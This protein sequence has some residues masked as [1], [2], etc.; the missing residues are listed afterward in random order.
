M[1][2]EITKHDTELIKE[3]ENKFSTIFSS[4]NKI[5][6]DMKNNIFSKY[7]IYL[8]ESNIIGFINY[9][10][11]YDR[12]E[13]ANIFVLEEYRNNKVASKLMEHIIALGEIKK[14]TNITLEVKKDNIYAIKLYKK[15][16][17]ETIALRKRYY[18]GIDGLLMER[19]MVQ[20]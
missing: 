1:I 8:Q 3:L 14:I 4:S 20:K 13:I 6:D 15:Y 18:N 16:N 2:I 7:F 10:D 9:Y 11:I 19:K 5:I 17:F 12:F